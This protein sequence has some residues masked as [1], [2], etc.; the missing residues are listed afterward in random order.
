MWRITLQIFIESRRAEILLVRKIYFNG[1]FCLSICLSVVD[2]IIVY[3]HDNFR[4]NYQ[5]RLRFVTVLKGPNKK[6][7]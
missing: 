7:S 2:V 1:G 5:I 4:K 3:E 6:M